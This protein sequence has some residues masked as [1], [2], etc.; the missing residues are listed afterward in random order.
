MPV[1]I[2]SIFF[3]SVFYLNMLKFM[4]PITIAALGEIIA[5]RSGIVNIGL[6]GLII[7]GALSS[8]FFGILS[9][10]VVIALLAGILTGILSGIVYAIIVIYLKGDQ[11]VTGIGLNLFAYGFGV[12]VLYFTWGTFANSPYLPSSSMMPKL[13]GVSPLIPL[14]IL[15][16]IITWYIFKYT[17]IGLRVKAVGEN[18]EV[19]ESAGINIYKVRTIA[20]II[21]ATLATM[22]GIFMGIDWLNQYTRDIS[23]GRGF[24]ALALVVFSNWNPLR[25]IVGGVIFGFL[26]AFSLSIPSGIIPDQFLGMLPYIATLLVAAG[27]AGKAKP[28]AALGK[29]YTRE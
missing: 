23:G 25:L 3:S 20:T 10:S 7:L 18:P 11:I 21:G 5:E 6:E 16:S 12:I 22:G 19:A 24:I 17:S 8:V 28:P 2:T 14:T 26:Y 9:S 1:D 29:P 15:L 13:W 27:Y 4:V